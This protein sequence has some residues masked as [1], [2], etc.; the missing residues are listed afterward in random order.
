MPNIIDDRSQDVMPQ[1][2]VITLFSLSGDEITR[3]KPQD[4]KV[5]I[6]D[7]LRQYFDLDGGYGSWLYLL[8]PIG[9]SESHLYTLA[10][11]QYHANKHFTVIPIEEN[12]SEQVHRAHDSSMERLG[13]SQCWN[14][15]KINKNTETVC[16]C[17]GRKLLD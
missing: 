1:D 7:T 10:T 4:V 8:F 17:C 3:W 16:R 11:A 12:H 6:E 15:L 9:E 5:R 14:C 13:L 2:I